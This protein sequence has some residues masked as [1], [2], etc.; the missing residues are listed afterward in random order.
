MKTYEPGFEI[1]PGHHLVER[2]GGGSFGECWK[3]EAPGGVFVAVKIIS[4]LNGIH[5]IREWQSLQ[6][7]KNL[8]HGNLVS[9][10][11]VWLRDESGKLLTEQQ[12]IEFIPQEPPPGSEPKSTP[13]KSLPP[14]TAAELKSS[15][16]QPSPFGG[17][18]REPRSH[19]NLS[20]ATLQYA[21][22]SLSGAPD[23]QPAPIGSTDTGSKGTDSKKP[24]SNSGSNES[25][26]NSM[27]KWS[28]WKDKVPPLELITVMTLGEGTL[29]DR[30][31][32]AQAAGEKGIA[33]DQLL[34]YMDD[35]AKGI[36]Y[37][38]KEDKAKKKEAIQHCDIKP[39]NL[40]V[41][42]DG[43]QVCDYGS[44][45]KGIYTAEARAHQG[46]T[47]QYAAPEQLAGKRVK[48]H[49]S[50]D[51]YALAMS[52]YALRTGKYPWGDL[53]TEPIPVIKQNERFDFSGLRALTRTNHEVDAIRKALYRDPAKRYATVTEFVDAL[54]DAVEAEETEVRT[55]RR[56]LVG[57]VLMGLAAIVLIALG[58]GGFVY[59]NDVKDWLQPRTAHEQL[60]RLV[61]DDGSLDALKNAVA[62][63]NEDAEL[64]DAADKTAATFADALR[65][66]DVASTDAILEELANL[67]PVYLSKPKLQKQ[68]VA[69]TEQ[70]PVLTD[71]RKDQFARAYRAANHERL[72]RLK[73]SKEV[74]Q[75]ELDLW[76]KKAKQ[77]FAD[78]VEDAD[79]APGDGLK[80]WYALYQ[81]FPAGKPEQLAVTAAFD[82]TLKERLAKI[83]EELA[84]NNLS[85]ARAARRQASAIA[86][87]IAA[88]SPNWDEATTTAFERLRLHAIIAE[89][90]AR[91]LLQDDGKQIALLEEA[92]AK[93]EAATPRDQ[94]RLDLLA[95]KLN[96]G[97]A[98][99]WLDKIFLQRL[100][101]AQASIALPWEQSLLDEVVATVFQQAEKAEAAG[102]L[103][104]E[105]RTLLE[106]FNQSSGIK[107]LAARNALKEA[108]AKYPWDAQKLAALQTKVEPANSA[109]Q[110]PEEQVAW[111]ALAAW[112]EFLVTPEN[113]G[114]PL[115]KGLEAFAKWRAANTDAARASAWQA[116]FAS[117]VVEQSRAWNAQQLSQAQQSISASK[118]ASPLA[119]RLKERHLQLLATDPELREQ[120]YDTIRTLCRELLASAQQEMS[121]QALPHV[122]HPA[123]A[124]AI[125]VE[126]SLAPGLLNNPQ[127]QPSEELAATMKRVQ[128][129][130]DG[131]F[132]DDA[133]PQ[134]R[135]YLRFVA[136]LHESFSQPTTLAWD[137]ASKSEWLQPRY[138][139]GLA[140][141]RLEV[142]AGPLDKLPRGIKFDGVLAAY[143]GRNWLEQAFAWSPSPS[144]AAKLALCDFYDGKANDWVQLHTWT[145]A[146]LADDQLASQLQPREAWY[147]L[148]LVDAAYHLQSKE[149]GAEAKAIASVAKLLADK[150]VFDPYQRSQSIDDGA[151]LTDPALF[152]RALLPLLPAL[153]Q[154]KEDQPQAVALLSGAI[155]SLLERDNSHELAVEH[156]GFNDPKAKPG[157]VYDAMQAAYE[158]AAALETQPE[159]QIRWLLGSAFARDQ[160]YELLEKRSAAFDSRK[161]LGKLVEQFK[162]IR[163]SIESRSPNHFAASTLAA[164]EDFYSI[165]EK[166]TF[167]D[168]TNDYDN[169][170]D[171]LV[172]AQQALEARKDQATPWCQSWKAALLQTR[173]IA[174]LEKS[175][176]LPWGVEK[177]KT[178]QA[179]VDDA[180]AATKIDDQF[181]ADPTRAYFALANAYEDTALDLNFPVLY[182]R[183]AAALETAQKLRGL[184]IFRKYQCR[185]KLLRMQYRQAL[186][187]T[188]ADRAMAR[189][190]LLDKYDELI[191][192][193]EELGYQGAAYEARRWQAQVHL[194]LFA[195][196]AEHQAAAEQIYADLAGKSVDLARA[197]YLLAALDCTSL[198]ESEDSL[199]NAETY[200]QELKPLEN[201]VSQPRNWALM[202]KMRAWTE[203]EKAMSTA[204]PT[205]YKEH[206]FKTF[207]AEIAK[208]L[209]SPPPAVETRALELKLDL[210]LALG[211]VQAVTDAQF[212][213][214]EAAL[215][216]A[217]A[218]A[219]AA[220]SKLNEELALRYEI[221]LSSKLARN[222]VEHA[223]VASKTPLPALDSKTATAQEKR[224]F[225]DAQKKIRSDRVKK[226]SRSALDNFFEAFRLSYKL[227]KQLPVL[228]YSDPQI[229][230]T[231]VGYEAAWERRGDI[232]EMFDSD[233]VKHATPEEK[234][235]LR[236]WLEDASDKL[237][238]R[239][240]RTK[241]S[242]DNTYLPALPPGSR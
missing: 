63:A 169:V 215:Q 9:I 129:A 185:E 32:H 194:K 10:F 168:Q 101:A 144:V 17:Q 42:G 131:A 26:S 154:A 223:A 151:P 94:A 201:L 96:T 110:A 184:D 50:T 218:A 81:E 126:A 39:E 231:A 232:C 183:A 132:E 11:S 179:A 119:M 219:R 221:L 195:G 213:A 109:N 43:V 227:E 3:A 30:L 166:S 210:A 72:H 108:S 162:S 128:A 55:R 155:G 75:R 112:R 190:D 197:N 146:A 105:I 117:A 137:A 220:S 62:L 175:W 164:M 107:L 224:A 102:K 56:R 142:L 73:I 216:S 111:Q 71:A 85:G 88:L 93:R 77:D 225:A 70:W 114:A 127:F 4:K 123:V 41:V 236:S 167:S 6:A 239:D 156:F 106:P 78:A 191:Q 174:R 27:A 98:T 28:K 65:T 165:R 209:A 217:L 47:E 64:Q 226:L 95:K 7:V 229:T 8:R 38:N 222:Y 25:D 29:M 49:G 91:R 172:K 139:R 208:L 234:V 2:L 58:V 228:K 157:Q 187:G 133:Y 120:D 19:A 87:A 233:L 125:S 57:R 207:E 180:L 61:Y 103:T 140:A 212:D 149:S 163:Q 160:R 116:D 203:T 193:L 83:E 177:Q 204:M 147:H 158:R 206:R 242:I 20:A 118:D 237:A 12:I 53:A 44:A 141:S 79:S 13:P 121:G 176:L 51:L 136:A 69:I 35:A 84:R 138:R 23:T 238:S 66:T 22:E 171:K 240:K 135:D 80:E 14:K 104:P 196:D 214:R 113:S 52:Y 211:D 182:Q 40:L 199:K 235:A 76:L 1:V 68:L 34:R 54:H 150:E 89:L 189:Q 46:Y 31:K 186:A 90:A 48:I 18:G 24:S 15:S 241:E 74:A 36:E 202:A 100:A 198:R 192:Q 148:L 181:R 134:Q 99:D 60:A 130:I 153:D 86:Q 45:L 122:L 143:S 16:A 33:R 230:A 178:L 161:E 37:L 200:L 97:E 152:Q 21:D 170:I 92:Q 82:E 59:R 5:A 67:D 173:S 205:P 188:A 124:E 159:R 145:S 115:A